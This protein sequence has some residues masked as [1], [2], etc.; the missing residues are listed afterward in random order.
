MVQLAVS[1]TTAWSCGRRPA[2][3]QDVQLIVSEEGLDAVFLVSV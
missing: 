2:G 3:G 1:I